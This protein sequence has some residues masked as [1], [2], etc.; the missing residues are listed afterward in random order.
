AELA[1]ALPLIKQFPS[2][3]AHLALMRDKTLLFD[4]KQRAFIMYDIAGRSWVTMGDPVGTDDDARR[5]LVWTFIEQCERAGGWP[6]FYQVSP[7]D[8]DMYLEVGM[9]PLK[10]GEEA[11][12]RLADF[13]LDGK[14]KKSLRGIVNKLTR[15]GLRL[16]IVLATAVAPLLPQLKQISDAWLRDKR[17]REKRFSLGTFDPDYLGRTPMAVVWQNDRPLA[18]ANLFLS[19]PRQEASLD[20]MRHVPDGP[21]G[22]MDYLFVQ[23]MQW[24][25]DEGYQWFNLG[26]A[27]LAGLQ[28]RRQAPLW[29]RFGAL[30]FGRGERFFNFRGL[31]HYK[32]NFDPE[33][34]PRYMAVPRGIALPMI[35]TN[36]AGLIAGGLT[37]VVRR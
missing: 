5:E 13:N 8:L 28:N 36:V 20:L 18:F 7:D 37:G 34:E 31:Q 21:T 1:Q 35:L 19:E 6:V 29:N 33:W 3:Q 22:I 14:S 12:V 30:V 10:I 25:R 2:T 27:P 15:E 11:R 26:M 23:L 32:N 24:A 17:V 4:S 16:E 9:Y